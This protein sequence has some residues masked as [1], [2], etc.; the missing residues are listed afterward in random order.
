VT[1]KQTAALGLHLLSVFDKLFTLTAPVPGPFLLFTGHPDH[2]QRVFVA[3]QVTVQ[4]QAERAAIA[5]VS[6]HPGVTFVELLRSD[7]LAV[8]A[9]LEQSTLEPVAKPAGFIDDMNLKAFV[10]LGFDP[11]DKF[12]GS[13][14]SGRARR[15]VVVLSHH[16]ELLTVNVKPELEQRAV[17]VYLR[18]SRLGRGGHT[19]KNGVLFHK[20]GE[21]TKTHPRPL[22]AIYVLLG[23]TAERVIRCA[24]SPVLA[25][26]RKPGVSLS[27]GKFW[28]RSISRPRRS[29]GC[30]TRSGWRGHSVQSSPS[31]ISLSGFGRWRG[32]KSMCT[33][34][35]R[36]FAKERKL[37][38]EELHLEVGRARR[39][40]R[41][42]GR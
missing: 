28:C 4:A 29:M 42:V 35:R 6:L 5:P 12:L 8:R 13:K 18:F 33:R 27:E 19:A 38:L 7:H 14:T 41:N 24:P 23:S 40:L 16:H 25:C 22:H 9:N 3:G 17:L 26:A 20:A 11:G 21:S 1:N 36:S 2:G 10:Q 30:A 32:S 37:R 15:S 34:W 39:L 31:C